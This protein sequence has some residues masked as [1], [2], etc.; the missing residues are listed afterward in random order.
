MKVTLRAPASACL[1]CDI[2]SV[3]LL[4][5]ALCLACDT[6]SV[7]LLTEALCLSCYSFLSLCEDKVPGVPEELQNPCCAFP[8]PRREQKEQG[9]FALPPGH[10]L[11]SL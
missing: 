8:G 11:L 1:S 9:D 10:W 4:T 6:L 3:Y 5:E 2:L 7:Y